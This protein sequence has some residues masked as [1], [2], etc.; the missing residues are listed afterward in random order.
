M[1]GELAKAYVALEVDFDNLDEDIKR[2]LEKRVRAAAKKAQ[3]ELDKTELAAAALGDTIDKEVGGSAEKAA[4]SI[5][6]AAKAAS[7]DLAKGAAKAGTNLDRAAKAA[8]KAAKA[9]TDLAKGAE[10]AKESL[11]GAAE[12]AEKARKGTKA[13]ADAVRDIPMLDGQ[14]MLFDIDD[15]KIV[16]LRRQVE[17]VQEALFDLDTVEI[18]KVTRS[19]DNVTHSSDR[20]ATSLRSRLLAAVVGVRNAFEGI[21]RR[22]G[23]GV[24]EDLGRGVEDLGRR[25]DRAG[26]S[27][28]SF[29][30][31]LAVLVS[32]IAAAATL[33]PVVAAGGLG[34]AAGVGL[35]IPTLV[36]VIKS[37]EEMAD[38]WD[39]L[40]REE[41]IASVATR[42][43]V[44]DFK[45]LSAELAPDSLRAYNGVLSET[46]R[47][48]PRLEPLAKAAFQ[49]LSNSLIDLGRGWDSPRAT[50][51]F[52]DMEQ[53]AAPALEAVT[54]LLMD[55]GAAVASLITALGPLVPV[56]MG[57]VTMLLQLITAVNDLAP[58]LTQAAV[59]A[60]A[61]RA[62]VGAIGGLLG[63][64]VRGVKEFSA[65]TKGAGLGTK[66]LNAATRAGPNIYL[67]AGAALA[68]FAL[69]V[70]QTE[71]AAERATKAVLAN[72]RAVGNNLAGYRRANAILR[73]QYAP[74]V[75]AVNNALDQLNKS[76]TVSNIAMLQGAQAAQNVD[77]AYRAAG[78]GVQDN[79]RH[80][81]NVT[82]AA[83]ILARE[84]GITQEAAIQL[85]NAAGV[86]LSRGVVES[87]RLIASAADKIGQYRDAANV[88]KSSTEVLDELF[89]TMGNTAL[90]T[91]DRVDA[92]NGALN[93][94]ANPAVQFAD[95]GVRMRKA[96]ADL[97]K[98]LRKTNLTADQRQEKATEFARSLLTYTE[99]EFAA[100]ES[101]RRSEKAYKDNRVELE[102]ALRKTREGPELLAAL[103]E[104]F[105]RLGVKA[106]EAAGGVRGAKDA[107]E[108][109]TGLDVAG[110]LAEAGAQA[111]LLGASAGGAAGNVGALAIEADKAGTK[112]RNAAL[113]LSEAA[114]QAGNLAGSASTAAGPVGGLATQTDR[115]G[116]NGL[117]AAGGLS[118][119]AQQA[120]GLTG[121]AGEAA[122]RAA[123]LAAESSRV[124]RGGLSAAAGM[125]EA[126]A[127]AGH[128]SGTASTAAANVGSLAQTAQGAGGKAATAAG[129]VRS[130][131]AQ[132]NNLPKSKSI[133]ITANTA[134]AR[135][136]LAS[137]LALIGQQRPSIPVAI[138]A[139]GT[140]GAT[141]GLLSSG[142]IRRAG[143]GPV[144][145]PRGGGLLRGPG[146]GT[147]D[148]ILALIDKG[149]RG[150]AWLSD[151]E[152]IVNA[153]STRKYLALLQAINADRFASGGQVGRG[154]IPGYASGGKVSGKVTRAPM[155]DVGALL[156]AD[157]RRGLRGSAKAIAAEVERI[158]KSLE[159]KLLAIGESVG[160]DFVKTIGT[161]SAKE[162]DSAFRSLEKR[163]TAAFRGIR[164]TVDD[165]LVARL[166]KQ[167][168]KLSDLAKRRDKLAKQ[169]EEATQL[170]ADVTSRARD[171]ANL[172][173]FDDAQQASARTIADT[174]RQR[175]A[176]IRDFQR[177]IETLARRGLDKGALRQIVEAG[178][179]EGGSL[180]R[181]LATASQGELNQISNLQRQIDKAT[182]S[183][184]TQSADLLFD[185]GRAAGKGFLAGLK[186]EE[187]EIIK[188]MTEIAKSVSKTV[189]KTLKI[190]SPSR[191][192]ERDGMNTMAG[193]ILGIRKLAARAR[194][195]V[196]TAVQPALATAARMTPPR[197]ATAG[198][199]AYARPT[200]PREVH[201][202]NQFTINQAYDPRAV[203]HQIETRLLAAMR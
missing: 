84:Y 131:G 21:G 33:A 127:Q 38:L 168:K 49:G 46:A 56:G 43:L 174:L 16:Q 9:S 35:A 90:G 39:A 120:A 183:L 78:L 198:A 169:I 191:V 86:D 54:G 187:K 94:L 135:G 48:L 122:T 52:R 148:S 10:K 23:S 190:K 150:L 112:G 29:S 132:I 13:A 17:A 192:L 115:A 36:R 189:K 184:G 152:F 83:K 108:K 91:A 25:T 154:G 31:R 11:G 81:R 180:A 179:D 118:A 186:A 176:A 80:I 67:A 151:Q 166:D 42:Q 82:E 202:H 114:A 155:V 123:L 77:S 153:R 40:S 47:M 64:S 165:R 22:G 79:D 104:T 149:R 72:A 111:G 71:T 55:T 146:T 99:A 139:P 143:G 136:A 51:F 102:K 41:R 106:E 172:A 32:A 4:A 96:E 159:K 170:A 133:D 85:A 12:A 98:A 121:K 92:L 105:G 161:G 138:R 66:L 2:G 160:K 8:E 125:S 167:N 95:A 145:Q 128:L 156:G 175:L 177:N 124:G 44:D 158:R 63:K 185:A 69:H 7:S 141:G 28:D 110:G 126:A 74:S 162:I 75:T 18:D 201:H 53:Q 97:E 60:L 199:P 164:T 113:G 65:A 6:K 109:L 57:A 119:A 144:R 5:R 58:G 89:E 24:L 134:P 93:R 27:L 195:A 194:S 37:Q 137:F 147:S 87:G 3:A 88:A 107:V 1:A 182:K 196:A 130:L 34:L 173:R 15:G 73:G 163:I 30:G 181:M 68:V 178:V 70:S 188:L 129:K 203:A 45:D 62:P 50:Q 59:L 140:A 197:S 101:T 103:E 193:Y 20:A 117:T 76:V 14:G 171:F 19:V 200:G 116:R 100:T 157:I 142:V 61:L 26:L